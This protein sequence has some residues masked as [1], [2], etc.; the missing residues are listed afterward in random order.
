MEKQRKK[1]R[2]IEEQREK[3]APE[4]PKNSPSDIPTFPLTEPKE[5]M[6][7][8]FPIGFIFNGKTMEKQRKIE[9]QMEKRFQQCLK[10]AFL[11]S[12]YSL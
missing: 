1:Q 8:G 6:S 2:K 11:I 9:E 4:V 5:G 12:L 3:R 7:P 10:I